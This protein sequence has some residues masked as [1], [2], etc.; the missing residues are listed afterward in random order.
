MDVVWTYSGVRPL[1]DDGS[2]KPEAA[3]RGYRLE[4]SGEGEGAPLLSVYGGKITTYR[5][6]A[7]EAVDRLAVRL[8]ALS[9]PASAITTSWHPTASSITASPMTSVR[10]RWAANRTVTRWRSA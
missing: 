3:T 4:L 9:G 8:P 7:E 1:I 2:G 6:L 10:T 5:H